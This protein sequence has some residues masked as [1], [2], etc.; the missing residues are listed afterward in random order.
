MTRNKRINY[1]RETMFFGVHAAVYQSGLEVQLRGPSSD[2][3]PDMLSS[4]PT[5]FLIPVDRKSK[6]WH[7]RALKVP[8][9]NLDELIQALEVIGEEVERGDQV[10]DS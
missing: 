5:V 1:D 4:K 10:Q 2:G 9:E 3:K 7:D 6:P 8:V